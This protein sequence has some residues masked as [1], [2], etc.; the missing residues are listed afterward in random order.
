MCHL[1]RAQYVL[2]THSRCSTMSSLGKSEAEGGS[3]MSRPARSALTLRAHGD[4]SGGNTLNS[5]AEKSTM[6]KWFSISSM[7]SAAAIGV[8]FALNSAIKAT[9]PLLGP[10]WLS[11]ETAS[12]VGSVCGK[13]GW[14]GQAY[15]F[16]QAL[17]NGVNKAK[18]IEGFAGTTV[19][20]H[21]QRVQS[22]IPRSVKSLSATSMPN[23]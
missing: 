14:A 16:G 9:V 7:P 4:T 3:G 6:R 10:R 19:P 22:T 23:T 21:S 11:P 12:K 15:S 1:F 5:S 17:R 18:E 2:V 20:A 13:I 8:G